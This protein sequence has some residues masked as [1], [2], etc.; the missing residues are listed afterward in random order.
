MHPSRSVGNIVG[1]FPG[2]WGAT[3]LEI[4]GDFAFGGTGRAHL[5]D[6]I[7]RMFFTWAQDE[8]AK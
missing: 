5:G 6:S 8:V 2:N 4:I 1:N 7:E 3:C